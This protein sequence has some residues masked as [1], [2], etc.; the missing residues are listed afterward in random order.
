MRNR[1]KNRF[2]ER[3]YKVVKHNAEYYH[4][5]E[6]SDYQYSNI[7]YY[8]SDAH[9][10]LCA[11]G[12]GKSELC[13][14]VREYRKHINRQQNNHRKNNDKQYRRVC[15][16]TFDRGAYF[17]YACVI[18]GKRSQ[19]GIKPAGAFSDLKH[20]YEI[21]REHFGFA[22]CSCYTAAGFYRAEYLF[23]KCRLVLILSVL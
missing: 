16:R 5:G 8:A 3:P 7:A 17:V 11:V 22:K 19:H 20:L 4:K 15:N 14:Y 13:E 1:T 18:V 10:P 23:E 21:V 9:N 2:S 6:Y 12:Q